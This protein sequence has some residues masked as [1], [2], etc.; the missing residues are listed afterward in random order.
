MNRADQKRFLKFI[1]PQTALERILESSRIRALP[2]EDIPIL[3]SFGRVLANDIRS[4]IDIPPYSR[5]WVDG[6]AVNSADVSQASS[7][8]PVVLRVKGKLLASGFPTEMT[9]SSGEAIYVACGAPIPSGADA[10]VKVEHTQLL[11]NN[12][13]ILNS[14]NPSAGVAFVGEDLKKGNL[15]LR[16]GQILRSQDVGL[17]AALAMKTVKV[18][19]KPVVAILSVGDEITEIDDSYPNKIINNYAMVIYGMALELG[20]TPLLLGVVPDVCQ[21]IKE[22]LQKGL[23]VADIVTTIGGCSVGLNDVVPDAIEALGPRGIIFHGV[24]VTPGHVVGAGVISQKP[25]VML[26]GHVTSAAM[27]FYLFVAPLI[28]LFSGCKV[29]DML[30][31]VA[32]K[33]ADASKSSS[34]HTFLRVHVRHG[35]GAYIAEPVHGGT[36]VLTNLAKANG[37]VLVPPKKTLR[38]GD[39]VEVTLFSRH[40]STEI[41]A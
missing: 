20:A 1:S 30:P 33:M 21:K 34:L 2:P 18:T 13:K 15:I 6:Y 7:R 26:P 12:I 11:D 14:I 35:N 40:E 38:R 24:S 31:S 27:A 25:I 41:K 28:C 22:A 5:T 32:A 3:E 37:Y 36:N 8:S 16:R 23:S 10:V 4:P 39:E 29:E 17:L 9:L 19:K